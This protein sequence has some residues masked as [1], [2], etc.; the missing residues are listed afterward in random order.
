VTAVRELSH[1]EAT[2]FPTQWY[3]VMEEGHFLLDWRM[4]AFEG[5]LR[6]LGLPLDAP[7][8][9]LDVGCG[10]GVLRRQVEAATAWTVDG[11]DVD[12]AVLDRNRVD[13]GETLLYDIRERNP[14]LHER[15]EFVLLFDVLEHLPEPRAFLEAIADHLV[16]GGWLYVNVPALP[17]LASTFDRVVGH[18]R[19]YD[20]DMLDAE[21]A[22]LP[23]VTRD[24]RYW[25]FPMLPYL[26][27]RKLAAPP[28]TETERVI[29]QGLTPP[30]AWMDRWIRIVAG[31]EARWLSRPP[32]GTSLLLAAQKEA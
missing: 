20:R 24:V 27:Y 8:R 26:V 23:F 10:H 6:A 19:R 22:G 12:R 18:L 29:E 25:G 4:R 3:D 17:R 31:L 9:G 32:V 7:W 30:A 16:P 11:A 2:D 13:R 5:Q 28:Q 14:E 1:V 21:F 15:Y